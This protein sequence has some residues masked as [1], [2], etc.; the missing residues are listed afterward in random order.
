M[1]HPESKD[2]HKIA[3]N[4]ALGASNSKKQ[5]DTTHEGAIPKTS[6][7]SSASTSKKVDLAVTMETLQL[8]PSSSE[9]TVTKRDWIRVKDS[10]ESIP[11]T[12][13]IICSK[14][15][16]CTISKDKCYLTTESPHSESLIGKA[17]NTPASSVSKVLQWDTWEKLGRKNKKENKRRKPEKCNEPSSS[18]SPTKDKDTNRKD[19]KSGDEALRQQLESIPVEE[20]SYDEY[21]YQPYKKTIRSVE[22]TNKVMVVYINKEDKVVGEAS[23]PL[24][25]ELEQQVRNKEMRRG[26]MPDVTFTRRSM[27]SEWFKK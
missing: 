12:S 21:A 7:D 16:S 9:E 3:A 23:E 4:G 18:I 19:F 20:A 6:K 22:F 24:K 11:Q 8:T 14:S 2:E 5:K 15:T 25:K 13:D 26:H 17:K 1:S 27:M 10:L